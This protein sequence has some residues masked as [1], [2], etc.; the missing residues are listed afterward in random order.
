MKTDIKNTNDNVV[1]ECE[2]RWIFAAMICVAGFYGGYTYSCR[3]GIFCNAQTA[4]FVLFGM[5]IGKAEWST[6]LYYLIPMASYL[7]GTIISELLPK[8]VKKISHIRWDTF[9]VAFEMVIILIIGFIPASAPVQICQ[10]M[11]NFICAMQYNTFRNAENIPA[12]TTFCTAHTR[13]LGVNLVKWIKHKN[14]K[15]YLKTSLF[16]ALLITSFIIGSLLAAFL[17]RYF[18]TKAI[19]FAEILLAAVFIDLLYADLIKEKG[20]LDRIPKGH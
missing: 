4:N 10:I 19:W 18:D 3:G 15:V 7:G 1:L 20:L 2:R 6:A 17:C 5:A 12:A 13:A 8:P 11:I 9:F 14:E 16:H